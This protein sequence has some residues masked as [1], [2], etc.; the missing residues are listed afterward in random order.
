MRMNYFICALA[1][2]PVKVAQRLIVAGFLNE[3]VQR[4]EQPA[5]AAH[6][7]ELIEQKFG[8]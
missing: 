1:A 5:V 4:L 6:L 8:S 7:N 2:F 3:V